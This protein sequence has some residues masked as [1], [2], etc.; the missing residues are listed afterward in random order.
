MHNVVFQ[1]FNEDTVNCI[2]AICILTI[3]INVNNLIIHSYLKYFEILY[4]KNHMGIIVIGNMP[5]YKFM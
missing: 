3:T 4:T 1:Q 2:K 5:G